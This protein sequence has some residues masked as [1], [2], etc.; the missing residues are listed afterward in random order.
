MCA[1]P[2]RP[3]PGGTR[4]QVE[5]GQRLSYPEPQPQAIPVCGRLQPY[6][7]CTHKPVVAYF[8]YVSMDAPATLLPRDQ[9]LG[10]QAE[11]ER[12]GQDA[13]GEAGGA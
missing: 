2:Q 11:A 3:G 7:I 6:V 12:A 8:N 5:G 10:A 1:R 13:G 4:P 9:H